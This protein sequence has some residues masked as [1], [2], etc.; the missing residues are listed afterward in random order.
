MTFRYLLIDS[1]PR[2][3]ALVLPSPFP[4]PLLSTMLDTIF[5]T[6]QTPNISLLSAPALS[7]VAAGMRSGLVVDIGWAETVVTGLCEYREVQTH[8]SVRGIKLLEEAV[9][10]MLAEA[11]DASVSQGAFKPTGIAEDVGQLI[12]FEEVEDVT[13]RM[14][15]CKPAKKIDVDECLRDLRL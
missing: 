9:F 14:G 15:W 10:E 4:H 6:F 1:R 5:N 12:S 13:V 8:R 7:T 2:R 11:I 3:M